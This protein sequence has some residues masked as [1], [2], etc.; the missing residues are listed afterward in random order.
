MRN[1]CILRVVKLEKI[2]GMI[3]QERFT[4]TQLACEELKSAQNWAAWF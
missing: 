1:L 4:V 2:G 3:Y